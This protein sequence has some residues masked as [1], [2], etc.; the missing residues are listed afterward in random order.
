MKKRHFFTLIELLVVIAIIAI[1]AGMLL[2][3]L[4]KA[5]NTAKKISCVNNLKQIGIQFTMYIDDNGDWCPS[6]AAKN[7]NTYVLQLA[8]L[9]DEAEAVTKG[10]FPTSI[11]GPY[12][13]PAATPPEGAAVTYYKSSYTPTLG[14]QVDPINGGIW[15][16]TIAG[17]GGT[18]VGGGAI[19]KY[20]TILNNSVIMKEGMLIQVSSRA[21]TDGNGNVWTAI[22]Y[23][24]YTKGSSLY[25]VAPGYDNH[26]KYANFLFKDMHVDAIKAGTQ[27][28]WTGLLNTNDEWV[29]KM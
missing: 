7:D 29:P 4:G 2:P 9:T 27:F 23:L 12:L 1:L 24:T 11:K 3:A 13:C 25:N 14:Q 19:R 8:G 22:E 18:W 16:P 21:L 17:K 20:G 6:F 26:S 28:G 15:N 10:I 5:K